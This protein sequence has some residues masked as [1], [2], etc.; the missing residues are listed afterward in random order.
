MKFTLAVIATVLAAVSAERPALSIQVK[1]GNFASL[2]GLEPSLTWSASTTSGD[3]EL[4]GGVDVAPQLSSD[5]LSMP[6]TLWGSA[7]TTV[8]SWGVK[9]RAEV[10]RD[11]MK[12]AAVEI[13]AEDEGADLSV[14]M[15]GTAG[16][17]FSVETVE[18]TKGITSN[19]AR[20]TLTPKFTVASKAL[21]VTATYAAGKTAV[22]LDASLEE[23]T[24]KVSQQLD[25]SNR[26]APSFSLQSGAVAV[27]WER[28]LGEGNTLT[29]T[30]KPNDS[31]DM[32]WKDS[33]WTATINMPVA[34]NKIGGANISVK[35]DVSF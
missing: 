25:D 2:D 32:E 21:D 20:I 23:Q 15:K 28:D 27:E 7:S 13:D 22:N 30:L 29:T 18:A 9:A 8:K 4:T 16:E 35:R 33:A 6:R 11:N 17:E 5:V 34:D 12:S 19:D 3:F 10:S 14:R 26:V 1:D 31:L 24:I